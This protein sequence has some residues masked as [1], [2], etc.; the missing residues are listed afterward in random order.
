MSQ[1]DSGSKT[2]QA[3]PKKRRDA[4]K[5]GD[6]A[7]SRDITSTLLLGFTFLLL[8]QLGPELSVQLSAFTVMVMSGSATTL[9]HNVLAV[10][11]EAFQLLLT[12]SAYCF[13]PLVALALLTEFAQTGPL[14]TFDKTKPQLSNLSFIAGVKRMLSMD[15]LIELLK[16]IAK[17]VLIFG[18]GVYAVIGSLPSI[19]NLPW[20][21]PS[22]TAQLMQSQFQTVIAWTFGVFVA[23]SLLDLS[24]QKYSH[25]KKLRMSLDDIKREFKD[26]EGDPTM[27]SHRQQTARE[28]SQENAT[29]SAR[30]ANVLIVNPTHI[31]IAIQYDKTKTP[32]PTVTAR[33]MGDT[34]MAM[35][36]AARDARVP[37]IRNIALA[38]QLLSKTNNGDVVPKELFS[39]VAEVIIWAE[40]V[41]K[42][43]KSNTSSKPLKMRTPGEDLSHY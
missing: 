34:A 15:S 35:R 42:Q 32:I 12:I 36:Y 25:A 28:W 30:E 22:S 27:K 11:Y 20:T 9:E 43:L 40:N 23:I 13:I 8:W 3:T 29:A 17:T 21:L 2:E 16:S 5:K 7:K 24:Y 1:Q 14:F 10:A 39:I 4:R 31:A 33:G 19:V 26:S 37:V 18:I 41:A 38:R 6:I